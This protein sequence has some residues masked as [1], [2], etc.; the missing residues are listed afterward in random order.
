MNISRSITT[1]GKDAYLDKNMFID[2]LCSLFEQNMYLR[3]TVSDI[4]RTSIKLMYFDGSER[5]LDIN[6]AL[7]ILEKTLALALIASK[8]D[9]V[10]TLVF[11]FRTNAND[12]SI[13]IVDVSSSYLGTI[14]SN[15]EYDF[16]CY[17]P[18]RY[19]ASVLERKGIISAANSEPLSET[20]QLQTGNVYES[21][22]LYEA[23]K[24][25]NAEDAAP[26]KKTR[27]RK[28]QAAA[29][30]DA[31]AAGNALAERA[32]KKS[33]KRAAKA[34]AA[35]APAAAEK[36]SRIRKELDAAGEAPAPKKTRT[37]RPTP[38][39]PSDEDK[40]LWTKSMPQWKKDV[41]ARKAARTRWRKAHPTLQDKLSKK[42]IASWK[43]P[44]VRNA[45]IKAMQK[46][47]RSAA[48]KKTIA[49]MKMYRA[50]GGFKKAVRAKKKE[51]K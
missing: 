9:V 4:Q 23:R 35:D 22:A 3:G 5:T 47:W 2:E 29:K 8:Y 31:Y 44:A 43:N 38:Y 19:I 42:A 28:A 16:Y 45:R 10:P 46:Y 41:S 11:F 14:G 33:V 20:I 7:S 36:P 1:K 12:Q 37:R 6:T 40:E 49:R 30:T 32:H 27:T 24:K 34:A 26:K 18:A 39:N 13:S 15:A 25:A 48:G 17:L 21:L 51:K 50:N